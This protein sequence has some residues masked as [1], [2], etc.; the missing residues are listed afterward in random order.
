MELA[1]GRLALRHFTLDDADF[2]VEL[3]N[4]RPASASACAGW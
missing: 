2:I 3:V 1:T 4:A